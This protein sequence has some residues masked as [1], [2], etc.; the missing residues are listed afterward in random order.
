ME[1]DGWAV[2]LA[3]IS[4]KGELAAGCVLS[5]RHIQLLRCQSREGRKLGLTGVCFFPLSDIDNYNGGE[6]SQ[7][8]TPLSLPWRRACRSDWQGRVKEL[9]SIWR[10]CDGKAAIRKRGEWAVKQRLQLS[11][12]PTEVVHSHWDEE[13]SSHVCNCLIPK[14]F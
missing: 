1:W 8:S 2:P 3:V 6:E 7:E 9:R 11:N 10:E 4:L 12:L 14:W 5:W 13:G